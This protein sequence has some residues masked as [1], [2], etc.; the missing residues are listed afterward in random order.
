LSAIAA[1]RP[2][3]G[4][5][6]GRPHQLPGDA[7]DLSDHRPVD[8]VVVVGLVIDLDDRLGLPDRIEMLQRVTGRIAGVVPALEGRDND[9]V[10]QF[11]Q[12]DAVRFRRGH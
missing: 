6:H 10:A 11:G 3:V 12:V 5:V 8:L 1:R 2:A 7:V 4:D 9:R